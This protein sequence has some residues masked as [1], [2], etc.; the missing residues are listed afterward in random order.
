MRYYLQLGAAAERMAGTLAERG[1]DVSGRTILRWVQ[2]FGPALSDEIRRYRTPVSTTWLVDETNVQIP[3]GDQVARG[4]A[5]YAQQCA[6]CHGANLEGHY[7]GPALDRPILLQAG[8]GT[9]VR[10]GDAAIL[11]ATIAREMPYDKPGS[12]SS[13]EDYDVTAYLLSRNGLL[14]AGTLAGPA[15]AAGI[16]VSLPPR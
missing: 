6:G 8:G 15:T 14:P 11:Y 4:E 3:V 10:P 5:V 9:A 16:A 1:I 13:L 2:K 12:L 7:I